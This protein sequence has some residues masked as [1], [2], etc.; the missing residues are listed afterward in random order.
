MVYIVADGKKHF[1]PSCKIVNEYGKQNV[2]IELIANYP[3]HSKEE[4]LKLQGFHIQ[5]T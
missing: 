1:T 3:C 4:L 5:N 2:K